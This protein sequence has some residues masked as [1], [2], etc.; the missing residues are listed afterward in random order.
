MYGSSVVVRDMT[1]IRPGDFGFDTDAELDS[2]LATRLSE[3]AVLIDRDRN[4]S[5]WYVMGWQ[6]AIDNIANRWAAEFVRF[7]Q[8]SRDSPIVRVDDFRVMT[9][10]DN[11]PGPAVLADLRRFPRALSIRYGVEMSV[12]PGTDAYI[13]NRSTLKGEP[14]YDG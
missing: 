14:P 10:T 7:T 9:P 13:G 4:R 3:I 2:W 8:S 11:V 5:D 6:P 12:V 1:G